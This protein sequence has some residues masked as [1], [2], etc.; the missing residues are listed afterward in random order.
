[1]I[2]SL[3][4]LFVFVIIII[5]IKKDIILT[6]ILTTDFARSLPYTVTWGGM[7]HPEDKDEGQAFKEI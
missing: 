3:A 2:E 5:Y 4:N 7:G 6:L 1:M